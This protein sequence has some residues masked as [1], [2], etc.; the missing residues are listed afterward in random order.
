VAEFSARRVAAIAA[1]AAA[2]V[3]GAVAAVVA[4]VASAGRQ[5]TTASASAAGGLATAAVVRTTLHNTVQVGG[6]IGYTGAY[7]IS[8]PSGSS[9]Q[10]V[11]QAH[12][13]VTQDR[14]TLA[15]DQK[16]ESDAS[17]ADGRTIAA[18]QTNV[19]TASATLKSDT[20]AKTHD[21]TGKRASGTVCTQDEQKVSQ[22]RIQLT[23]AQ[24]QLAGA[25]LTAT[26]DHDQNAGKVGADQIKLRG[27]RA[28]LASL[29]AT[30]A[31]A[32]TTV[33]WLPQTGAIIGQ[34]RP[35]YSVSNEPVPL[36]YGPVA[37][38]RA[39]HVGMSDGADVRQLAA[40]LIALGDGAGLHPSDH[41]S[42]AT[43]TAV[44]RW[45]RTLGLPATGQILLGQVVFEPGPIRV[46]SVTASVGTSIGG[47]GGASTGGAG[48]G[49]GGG[50]TVLTATSAAPDVAVQLDVTDEY[51]VKRGDTVSVVLPNGTS[52]VPGRI[53]NVGNVAACPGGGG[54]GLGNAT[55]GS[56]ADQSQCAS[57]GS[58]TSS[59][60]TVTVTIRL[61][62]TPPGAK[63]DQAPVNVNI[64]SQTAKNVLAVPVNALLALQGGGYGVDVVTARGSRLVG[65]TT[66]LYSN[67]LVQVSGPGIA[68]GMRVQVPAS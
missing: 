36:L 16:T 47:G 65:V 34:D 31:P 32:G 37:D 51:L 12:Q 38:Y 2:M 33:T 61:Q 46:T 68:A 59:S 39:F 45:Q 56:T 41:Y 23:Q 52:T 62:R 17:T 49:G 5:T 58:G 8:T 64:T 15:A 14:Q 13:T 3:G 42:T 60:P 48:G 20:G 35:V 1:V 4:M 7:T 40:D 27:D 57:S 19:G 24:Q 26:L 10:E 18:D 30:A 29:Q 53:Q 50:G 6:S 25:T 55:G 67:T 63:L 28:T 43:A 44:K 66:G 9:A 21:C 11:L 54:T 22:D